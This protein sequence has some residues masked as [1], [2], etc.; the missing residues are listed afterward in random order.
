MSTG[1]MA[2]SSKAAIPVYSVVTTCTLICLQKAQQTAEA[3]RAAQAAA[4]RAEL[5][6]LRVRRARDAFVASMSCARRSNCLT[7][8]RCSCRHLLCH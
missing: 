8:C 3:A 2:G 1:G 4:D 7:L 6:Q 5:Q